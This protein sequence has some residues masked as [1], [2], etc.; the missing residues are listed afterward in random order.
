MM[1]KADFLQPNQIGTFL[2]H[3]IVNA[4][5]FG[6]E[7]NVRFMI[8]NLAKL[9]T[10]DGNDLLLMS[11]LLALNNFKNL[12]LLEPY[13]LTNEQV[14]LSGISKCYN[15]LIKKT[16]FDQKFKEIDP[17]IPYSSPSPCKNLTMNPDCVPYC[18]WQEKVF[19]KLNTSQIDEIERYLNMCF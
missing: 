12:D 7:E 10:I 14:D 18:N 2:H 4:I 13:E 3:A 11:K 17:N 1:A 5:R 16:E 6:T 8:Q 9:L 19:S 15:G